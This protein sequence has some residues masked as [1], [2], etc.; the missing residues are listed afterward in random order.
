MSDSRPPK[1]FRLKV[2][3]D[4]DS[5]SYAGEV[6]RSFR[7]IESEKLIGRDVKS[8]GN[9]VERIVSADDVCLVIRR[10]ADFVSI[11]DIQC[12]AAEILVEVDGG[13]IIVERAE[14][15]AEFSENICQCLSLLYV[16]DDTVR[17]GVR[18]IW[19]ACDRAGNGRAGD[20]RVRAGNVDT[21]RVRAGNIDTG[22]VHTGSVDEGVCCR[23]RGEGI[24]G[25]GF[26]HCFR[27]QNGVN[28]V[29]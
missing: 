24:T 14:A 11:R 29:V 9:I 1:L 21:G 6:I 13:I 19:K 2:A 3:G 7:R 28:H 10:E 12:Q 20:R 23:T 15:D 18:Y 16:V 26:C 8:D 4:V 25:R 5:A 22:S 27:F 17:H